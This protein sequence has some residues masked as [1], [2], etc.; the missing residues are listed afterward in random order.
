MSDYGYPSAPAGNP[1]GQMPMNQPP[2]VYPK[3]D[4]G[5]VL[6]TTAGLVGKNFVSFSA[7]AVLFA[8]P[9]LILNGIIAKIV[10]GS[11][12]AMQQAAMSGDFRAMLDAFPMNSVI[13][14]MVGGFLNAVLV[15]MGMGTLMYAAV[16]SLAGRQRSVGEV[17]SRGMSSGPS[18]AIVAVVLMVA[19]T[20]SVLPGGIAMTLATIGAAAGGFEA[21]LCCLLPTGLLMVLIPFVYVVIVLFLAIPS[22]VLE[23]IG[24][25]AA[26]SRSVQL[27]KGHRGTIFLIIFLMGLVMIF[28]AFVLGLLGGGSNQIDPTTMQFQEP[29]M[30]SYIM[31][32]FTQFIMTMFR[33]VVTG[34]LA[35][36]I[37]AR[38]R[39]LKD[40]VD[41]NAI[42]Q[43]FS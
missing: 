21:M 13:F 20:V 5:D 15:Y 42:A 1:M 27:T 34:A 37:Y 6:Q 9:G 26:L 22:A 14:S 10:M 23:G 8:V 3:L 41:A 18:V 39:G 31:N 33:I 35:S 16:E 17:L 30:F 29:T 7:V 38:I 28:L 11:M 32:L 40:G 2:P 24:P 43:V 12:V 4:V 36:V 25:I 19:Q